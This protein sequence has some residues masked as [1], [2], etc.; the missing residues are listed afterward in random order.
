MNINRKMAAAAAGKFAWI[1][2]NAKRIAAQIGGESGRAGGR[3]E[4]VNYSKFVS[5]F[6]NYR[7]KKHY[8]NQSKA[9]REMRHTN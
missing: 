7:Q 5:P 2:N 8:E 6:F 4:Q 3:K 9:C 1:F